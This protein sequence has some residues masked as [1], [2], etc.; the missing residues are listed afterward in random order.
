MSILRA[1][2][3]NLALFEKVLSNSNHFLSL[4]DSKVFALLP[5]VEQSFLVQMNQLSA[6]SKSGCS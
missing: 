3:S 4:I 1:A 2:T 6:S 5:R